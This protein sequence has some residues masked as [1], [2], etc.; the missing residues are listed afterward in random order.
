MLRI[1]ISKAAFRIHSSEDGELI[2]F[3]HQKQKDQMQPVFVYLHWVQ[4]PKSDSK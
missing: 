3:K 4:T 1:H 2:R